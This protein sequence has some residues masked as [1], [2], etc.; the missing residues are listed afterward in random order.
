MCACRA[1]LPDGSTVAMT[2]ALRKAVLGA[3]EDMAEGALRCLALAR[4][5]TDQLDVLKDYN[6]SASHP[7]HKLLQVTVVVKR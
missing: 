7:G 2:P 3:V 6:G 1:L 4:K 5:D